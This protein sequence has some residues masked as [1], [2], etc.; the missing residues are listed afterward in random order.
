MARKATGA[1][2]E[3]HYPDRTTF[4]I[5]F[6]ALGER[7]YYTLGTSAEGYTREQAEAELG[8]VL[9][10]V[11]LGVWRPPGPDPAA[12]G[13]AEDPTFRKFASEWWDAK[14]REIA[15]TT[16]VAYRW[17]LFDLLMPFFGDYRLSQID[18]RLV[19][20]FRGELVKRQEAGER[21]SNR[22]IN[23]TLMR[24][25]QI[26]D[27]AVDYGL[28][29]RNAARGRNRR[30]KVSQA[31]VAWLDRAEHIAAIVSAAGQLDG[32]ARED[33]RHVCRRAIVATMVF[34]GLRIGELCALRWRDVQLAAGR[35]RVGKSKTDA[36]VRFVEMAP[37]LR[38]EL[39]EYK[40][41]RLDA[42]DEFVFATARGASPLAGNV[43]KRVFRKAVDRANELLARDDRDPLPE[44]LTPHSMRHTFTSLLTALG[45]DPG[46][47]MDQ[48]GHTDPAFTFRVY[49]H[50]MRRDDGERD[51]LRAL[52]NGTY[53]WAP[54]GT[55]GAED[56]SGTSA[57]R[58]AAGREAR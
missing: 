43:D 47:I 19:D 56:V 51:R 36:G 26:L 31:Q 39:A 34:A 8:D 1:V 3:R 18:A 40:A 49:R 27:L 54:L 30:L 58:V 5:R 53:D 29:E 35:I 23:A 48:L 6:R 20:R 13:R 4:A 57:A 55:R 2:I 25:A 44:G 32:E 37:A 7:H 45:E 17:E 16:A 46:H 33:R 52:W 15:D 38:D 9:G 50:S 21:L 12:D 11:R 41:T 24:L 22:T 42:P 14:G 28:A 10:A